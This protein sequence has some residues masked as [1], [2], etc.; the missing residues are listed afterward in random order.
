[1]VIV[2]ALL[3]GRW[4]IGAMVLPY[5]LILSRG[6]SSGGW[7]AA[8]AL[9]ASLLYAMACIDE[10]MLRREDELRLALVRH[11]GQSHPEVLAVA[12]TMFG[13]IAA[14][15][16]LVVLLIQ[17]WAGMA[18]LAAL[19]LI[20]LG[21]GS[22]DDSRAR[23]MLRWSEFTLPLIA[24]VIPL[25]LVRV[26]AAQ[27]LRDDVAHAYDP[28]AA[29]VAAQHLMVSDGLGA[30]GVLAVLLGAGLLSGSLLLCIMRDEHADRGAAITT[31][32]TLLGRRG[33][34]LVLTLITVFVGAM[35]I[36]GAAKGCWSWGVPIVAFAL[37]QLA[38]WAVLIK[39]ERI[40]APAW[41]VVSIGIGLAI[42]L[43]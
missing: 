14:L 26:Y 6:A 19:V 9:L 36:A 16:S 27:S 12:R 39:S 34:A 38:L 21:L 33:A 3:A 41:M 30:C 22:D 37:A 2:R 23:W 11:R 17:P 4:V 15:L 24:L 8:L 1:M 10:L 43:A 5:A 7:P 42:L 13:S 25:I 32:A 18:L 20:R 28:A 31:T 40:A 29:E 35:A